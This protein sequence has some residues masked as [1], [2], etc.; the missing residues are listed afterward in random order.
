MGE[1]RGFKKVLKLFLLLSLISIFS[2]ALLG[3]G[4]GGG[5][6]DNDDNSE[7]SV[8][9]SNF[10]GIFNGTLTIG[11]CEPS[12]IVTIGD[13]YS[14]KDEDIYIYIP[15]DESTVEYSGIDEDGHPY[16][17]NIQVSGSTISMDQEGGPDENAPDWFE[18]VTLYYSNNDNT[19]TVSG[20]HEETNPDA[21]G[22][23]CQGTVSG[24]F[25]R[26][27]IS[28]EDSI[29][30]AWDVMRE[31]TYVSAVFYSNGVYVN[32]D[33]G[34]E[35]GTYTH[36]NT[37]GEFSI[38]VIVDENGENGHADSGAPYDDI[39]FVSNDTV[40][41]SED[42]EASNFERVLDDEALIVGAWDVTEDA[43]NGSLVFYSDGAYIVYDDGVEYGTYTHD[44]NTGDFSITVIVDENG[45]NGLA[46]SGTPYDATITVENDIITIIEGAE[47]TT[48][49]RVQ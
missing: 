25:N 30:G 3:C 32:Y 42:G 27:E 9:N 26:I 7:T 20:T 36:D 19:I 29:V 1:S 23:D 38:S 18:S 43:P 28:E 37:T 35:Y 6:S 31:T 14:R 21:S 34:V 10:F 16:T 8:D 39:I 2:I 15:E 41:I 40:Y 11:D 22:Y 24:T 5:G 12:I 46:D 49:N 45:E 4:G 33:D 44:N 13:D 17:T 48:F 47:T